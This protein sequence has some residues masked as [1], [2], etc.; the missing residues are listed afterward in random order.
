V[1]GILLAHVEAKDIAV[2]GAGAVLI[3]GAQRNVADSLQLHN[4]L[5]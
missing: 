4:D 3:D 5:L 1:V 2:E